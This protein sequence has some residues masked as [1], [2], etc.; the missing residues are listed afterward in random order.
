MSSASVPAVKSPAPTTSTPLRA[1]EAISSVCVVTRAGHERQKH[2][3]AID[4]TASTR[5]A[6]AILTRLPPGPTIRLSRGV[7]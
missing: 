3:L 5:N 1:I 7:L 6:P 4:A 2:P